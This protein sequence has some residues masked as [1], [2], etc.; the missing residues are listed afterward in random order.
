MIALREEHRAV[1]EDGGG[2][3]ERL[4][5]GRHQ[6]PLARREVVAHDRTAPN[7]GASGPDR[8]TLADGPN[9]DLERRALIDSPAPMVES[10]AH[11]RAKVVDEDRLARARRCP[12]IENPCS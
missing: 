4:A 10:A 9:L 12:R 3:A 5:T 6:H 8:E 1:V 2:V 11:P 7:P